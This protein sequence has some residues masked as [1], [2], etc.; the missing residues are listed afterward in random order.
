MNFNL[1]KSRY[2][3]VRLCLTL[4]LLF[5]LT[6]KVIKKVKSKRHFQVFVLS[7]KPLLSISTKPEIRTVCS[8]APRLS[9]NITINFN[10]LFLFNPIN[11]KKE[12]RRSLFIQMILLVNCKKFLWFKDKV[13]IKK[14]SNYLILYL[15]RKFSKDCIFIETFKKFQK[16]LEL[17]IKNLLE[18]MNKVYLIIIFWI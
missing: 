17:E 7:H 18:E 16:Q 12:L 5:S 8:K 10:Q 9:N 4:Q 6:K 2:L 13:L 15:V 1:D 3:A 14:K 11:R